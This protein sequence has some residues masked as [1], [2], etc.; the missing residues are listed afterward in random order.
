MQDPRDIR[1]ICL[2]CFGTLDPRTR[3][4]TR[5]GKRAT[6][7]VTALGAL[8][9]RTLLAGRY[10]IGLPLGRGG[11]GITYKAYDILTCT[12]VAIKEFFP[13]GYTKRAPR[14]TAVEVDGP[15]NARAFNYWLTAFI[16]EA[17]V[18]TSIK[19][20]DG[21]VSIYDFFLTNNTA[22]IAMEYLN[23]MS[24]HHFI[25]GR[26]GRLS[27]S[28]T[29]NIMRPVLETMLRLHQHGVIHKDIS[30]ENIQIVDNKAIKLIDFGAASI[31]TQNVQKPF[32]V[33]KK[34]YSPLELYTQGGSQGPWTDIYE[35]G[36]TIYTCLVGN[37]PPEATERRLNDRIV[38][39][40][41]LNVKI[42][43]VR[44]KSLLKALSIYPKDRYSNIAAFQQMFYGEFMPN[45]FVHSK[46]Q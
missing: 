25:N 28:E 4:C 33:L 42:Q 18:L 37:P 44:E 32:F 14:A 12:A 40:S 41:M 16:Q 7:E 34:G 8:P 30:P 35:L 23:G 27:M 21:I 24:L 20:L 13:K 6:D 43:P 46:T 38:P 5:C 17:K 9:L 22:Y 15:D 11:F 39:P 31:Y 3:I 2:H 1:T 26:G 45:S 29:L 10:L 19:H 36:A